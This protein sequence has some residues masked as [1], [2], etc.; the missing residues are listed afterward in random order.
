MVSDIRELEGMGRGQT[1]GR[2]RIGNHL[3]VSRMG[4]HAKL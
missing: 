4:D 2:V 1:R 3:A